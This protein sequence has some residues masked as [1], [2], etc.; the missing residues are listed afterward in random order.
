MTPVEF[1]EKLINL[2]LQNKSKMTESIDE[3]DLILGVNSP[4]SS[5]QNKFRN[6][7]IISENDFK[8][9]LKTVNVI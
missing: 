1:E 8:N 4:Q 6:Q 5:V 7:D 3:K 2:V 9:S